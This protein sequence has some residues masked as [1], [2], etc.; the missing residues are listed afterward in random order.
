MENQKFLDLLC[1]PAQLGLVIFLTPP[2]ACAIFL[3]SNVLRSNVEKTE[4]QGVKNTEGQ[5]RI[6]PVSGTLTE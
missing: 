1:F 4:T 3:H 2:G 5:K 6:D